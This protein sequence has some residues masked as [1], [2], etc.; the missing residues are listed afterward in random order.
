[1]TP[2]QFRLPSIPLRAVV[3]IITIIVVIPADD[4]ITV[5][6]QIPIP[7]SFVDTQRFSN[8]QGHRDVALKIGLAKKTKQYERLKVEVELLK[9]ARGR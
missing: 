4:E 8:Y 2:L 9:N 6:I 1:M 7:R 3:I 5:M